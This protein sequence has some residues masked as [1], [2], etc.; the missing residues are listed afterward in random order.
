[1]TSQLMYCFFFVF[2][3][4]YTK[5]YYP[6]YILLYFILPFESSRKSEM[7]RVSHKNPGKLV[8]SPLV[9]VF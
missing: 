4:N 8:Y 2:F 1:M 9:Y 5:L 7:S 6:T 3:F